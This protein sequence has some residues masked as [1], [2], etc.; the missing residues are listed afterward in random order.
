[1]KKI[2]LKI[3]AVLSMGF[4]FGAC[5][6]NAI[7]ERTDYVESGAMIRFSHASQ[8]APMV[9][10]YL[11]DKKVTAKSPT[12]SNRE[13]GLFWSSTLANTIHPATYGYVNVPAGAYTLNAID[14]TTVAGTTALKKNVVVSM[15][16]QLEESKFYTSYLVGGAGNLE[17]LTIKDELPEPDFSKAYVRFVN[18]MAGAPT[19]F[20]VE[21]TR[22]APTTGSQTIATDVAFKG[23]SG[24]VAIEPGTYNL[25]LFLQGATKAYTTWTSGSIVAGRVYTFYTKGNYTTTPGT[26]NRQL[27]RER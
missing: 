12:L 21:A 1:M 9:N 18:G 19:G 16:V 11:G 2:Y 7:P 22:T 6:E 26:I 27:L 13:T 5:E 24:Y 3:A 8:D 4:L 14:T 23:N 25:A 20:T 17:I 10:F 15:P